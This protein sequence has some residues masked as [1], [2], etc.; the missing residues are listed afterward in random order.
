[1]KKNILLFLAMHLCLTSCKSLTEVNGT[2]K[3]AYTRQAVL[4]EVNIRQY[5]PE[6]TFNAFAQHLPYLKKLGVDI[7][8]LMPIHP[9]SELNRKGELGSYYAVQDYKAVNPEFG[10][11][12][13]FKSLVQQA[14]DLD[15]RII[16]DW[17]A[18]HTG[19]DHA[20]VTDHPTW[21]EYDELG[22]LASPLDWTDTYSL[23]YDNKDMRAAMI[24]AMCYWV[25]EVG[26][27]GYRCDV[28]SMVPTDFWRSV[29]KQ[30]DSVKPVFMLAE[31]S[32]ADLTANAFDMVYNWPA[33]FLFEEVVKG[34][35]TAQEIGN[36]V[37]KQLRKFPSDT[38]F[39]NHITNHDRNSWDGTEF[40]RLGNGVEAFAALTYVM[41]GMPLIYTGQEVGLRDRI[42][43]FTKYDGYTQEEN[44]TFQFYSRLNQLKK[45]QPALAAGKVGGQWA[46]YKTTAP[47]QVLFCGREL[48]DKEVIYVANLS[49]EKVVF[50]VKDEVPEGAFVEYF[51]G[52]VIDFSDT[53][54]MVLEPWQ[55]GI[56]IRK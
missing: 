37:S 31:S 34:K 29:R 48:L 16:I 50:D 5:T 6:G 15:M 8:W 44:N 3:P 27:D 56:Y 13:D 2:V 23:N 25:K 28:A 7:L 38:Y 18:N 21:Y 9:I 55:Y 11:L 33:M 14:H 47:R 10:T 4:Y 52:N 20:W 12:A 42:P 49:D 39:M 24:D 32:E 36:L 40:E 22:N 46:V 1:M 45:S 30:L 41:P 26:I 53:E 54:T 17:V 51:Y 35:K 43:F 19:C